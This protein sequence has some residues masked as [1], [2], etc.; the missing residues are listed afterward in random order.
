[1]SECIE[2]EDLQPL[3]FIV[4]GIW[5]QYW[6]TYII[7]NMKNN[8]K[9]DDKDGDKSDGK[10]KACFKR[11]KPAIPTMLLLWQII[12]MLLNFYLDFSAFKDY[13]DS[14]N[15][16]AAFLIYNCYAQRIIVSSNFKKAASLVMTLM[17]WMYT[18][19]L[20]GTGNQKEIGLDTIE[21]DQE[22]DNNNNENGKTETKINENKDNEEDSK[23]FTIWDCINKPLKGI[24]WLLAIIYLLTYIPVGITHGFVGFIAYVWV[25]LFVYILCILF[26]FIVF[27]LKRI[28]KCCC[29]QKWWELIGGGHEFEG[30]INW[31]RCCG[32]K[33]CSD[34]DDFNEEEN[35]NNIKGLSSPL[36][37]SAV[38]IVY[39]TLILT[40]GY[41]YGGD[42][43]IEAFDRV[44]NERKIVDYM[45]GRAES[46][47]DGYAFV[48][49]LF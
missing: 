10:C 40:C 22:N 3:W 33:C 24:W 48:A 15:D 49:T 26:S 5:I 12:S 9:S 29:N 31:I 47:G 6:V 36:T 13:Y 37:F 34:K 39:T 2:S 25:A 16:Q 46:I 18:S 35:G 23:S 38:L 8:A 30:F 17:V 42:T 45:A 41:W 19:C 43:Y 4:I 21:T 20:V 32:C 14:N 44:I 7:D 28:C 11:I 1:M 27:L